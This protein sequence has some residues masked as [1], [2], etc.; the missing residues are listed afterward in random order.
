MFFG[1]F[2]TIQEIQDGE[3]VVAAIWEH[4]IIRHH[5][6]MWLSKKT[7]LETLKIYEL[8]KRTE[9]PVLKSKYRVKSGIFLTKTLHCT[10]QIRVPS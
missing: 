9:S 2:G 4:V 3:S 1:G 6:V 7:I 5:I 8:C 10:L